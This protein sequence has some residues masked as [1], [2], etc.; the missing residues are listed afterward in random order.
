MWKGISKLR[1]G[2][3]ATFADTAADSEPRYTTYWCLDGIVAERRGQLFAGS[4][5]DAVD[6]LE[7]LMSEVIKLQMCADV[8]VGVLLSGGVDSSAVAA[9]M[10]REASGKVRSFSVGFDDERFDE[11]QYARQVAQHL[12]TVHTDVHVGADSALGVVESLSTMF[13][14][15]FADSSAIPTFIV[16]KAA[17]EVVKVV[18]TGD[19]GDESL[20]GYSRYTMGS[21]LL[22][23]LSCVP[24]VGTR[25]MSQLMG[26]RSTAAVHRAMHALH[27]RS[28]GGSVYSRIGRHYDLLGALLEDPSW[29]GLSNTLTAPWPR[30]HAGAV[31]SA[32]DFSQESFES[33]MHLSMAERM[34]LR[35]ACSYLPDDILA[36]VDRCSMAVGLESRAPLLDHRLVEFFWRLPLPL[37]LE[38]RKTKVVLR[39]LLTRYVPAQYIDRP[40][41]G[42]SV[43]LAKWL[44]GPL[45]DW[46]SSL[47]DRKALIAG[48]FEKPA[49]VMDLWN[50]CRSGYRGGYNALWAVLMWQCWMRDQSAMR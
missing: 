6:E 29:T 49:Y 46:A 32:P 47:L 40:K 4:L 17:R 31:G 26:E 8:P 13:D 43:P 41:M 28:G 11:S 22:T 37:K 9:F 16:C 3:I 5:Q 24:R 27:I 33:A 48:G 19:G 10:A 14:E 45:Y 36:K 12:G 35:D 44:R 15:P 20:C 25:M 21:R 38:G 2:T 34:M 23:A 18:L 42:F 30:N 50:R 7:E 1:P 39:T